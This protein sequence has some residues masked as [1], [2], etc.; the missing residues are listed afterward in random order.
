MI[1]RSFRGA[2]FGGGRQPAGAKKYSCFRN[3]LL[4]SF[5]SCG[6]MN[7]EISFN[8]EVKYMDGGSSCSRGSEN[9]DGWP[10]VS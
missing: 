2:D 9:G 6:N 1:S 3:F 4:Q 5:F 10:S 8:C 7:K